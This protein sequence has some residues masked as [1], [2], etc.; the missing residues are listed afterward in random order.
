[1]MWNYKGVYSVVVCDIISA[2]MFIL[3]IGGQKSVFYCHYPDQLLTK[4]E[5]LLKKAYR[6]PIDW[7]EGFGISFSDVILVNSNFTKGVFHSTFK[8]LNVNTRVLYPT[9][10]FSAFDKKITGNLDIKLEGVESLF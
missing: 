9:V 3:K 5:S 1:F 4:R 6:Y 2:F 10:N 7:L 8:S